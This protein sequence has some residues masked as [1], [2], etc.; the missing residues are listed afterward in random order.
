MP[1]NQLKIFFIYLIHQDHTLILHWSHIRRAVDA[2]P[3]EL[4][5]KVLERELRKDEHTRCLDSMLVD[6]LWAN[7]VLGGE[8]VLGHVGKGSDAKRCMRLAL[9][10]L[11]N[12]CKTLNNPAFR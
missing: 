11:R 3:V 4:E 1:T 12:A 5:R 2:S 8:L 6:V 9:V 7:H 10:Q